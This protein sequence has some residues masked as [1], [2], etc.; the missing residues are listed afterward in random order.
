METHSQ[1]VRRNA[2]PDVRLK[3]TPQIHSNRRWT[4]E[5][6]KANYAFKVDGLYF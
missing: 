2:F 6:C 4:W 3:F 5:H 1:W